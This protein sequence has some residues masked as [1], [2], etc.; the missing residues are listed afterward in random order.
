MNIQV[1]RLTENP[2]LY[3]ILVI[4]AFGNEFHSRTNEE[5]YKYH[6]PASLRHMAEDTIMAFGI[7]LD[8]EDQPRNERHEFFRD[9]T[10]GEV[11]DAARTFGEALFEAD[12]IL[13]E[14]ERSKGNPAW[15]EALLEEEK[16]TSEI[17]KEELSLLEVNPEEPEEEAEMGARH[18]KAKYRNQYGNLVV[19]VESISG[20]YYA[21]VVRPEDGYEV[22]VETPERTPLEAARYAL[23]ILARIARGEP[24]EDEAWREAGEMLGQDALEAISDIEMSGANMGARRQIECVFECPTGQRGPFPIWSRKDE[25]VEQTCLRGLRDIAKVDEP[26]IP[27]CKRISSRYIE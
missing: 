4:D 13:V 14:K 25:S 8:A 16:R 10:H 9:K 20:V 6:P 5:R 15:R 22:T 17:A 7:E 12:A 26:Q 27:L 18:P 1:T 3:D 24:V 19:T 23:Y 21:N 2:D 11:L